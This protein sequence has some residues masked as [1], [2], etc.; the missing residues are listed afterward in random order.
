MQSTNEAGTSGPDRT[1]RRARARATARVI[2]LQAFYTHLA[3]FIAVNVLLFAID[4]IANGA[5]DWAYWP[6]FGWGIGLVAHAAATFRMIPGV[7]SGWRERKI[8][9]LTEAELRRESTTRS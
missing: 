3:V 9:E 5:I 7:G 1:V 2:E 6:A 4:I 8:A